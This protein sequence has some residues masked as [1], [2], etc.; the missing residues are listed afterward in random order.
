VTNGKIGRKESRKEVGESHNSDLETKL[1]WGQDGK[2]TSEKKKEERTDAHGRKS[3][4]VRGFGT[5][6]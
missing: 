3:N 5:G 4:G 1:S 2:G 6:Q